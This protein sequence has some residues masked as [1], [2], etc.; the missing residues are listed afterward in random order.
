[1]DGSL[2]EVCICP[3]GFTGITCSEPTDA[4]DSCHQHEDTHICRHGGL[5]REVVIGANEIEWKCDCEIADEVNSFAGAMCRRPAT[6]YC[7]VHGTSFCTNGG[8]CVNNLVHAK[9]EATG[10]CICPPEFT[11]PHCE[12]LKVL[13]DNQ[14]VTH[15][16]SE[17][18]QILSKGIDTK[19]TE[20]NQER[21]PTPL[22]LS[23]VGIAA[24]LSIV[25]WKRRQ[26]A[27]SRRES[28]ESYSYEQSIFPLSPTGYHG[29]DGDNSFNEEE[30]VLQDVTLT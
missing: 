30:Y 29:N 19:G 9:F 22:T 2:R 20:N 8:T 16:V 28:S 1:V 11:G 13:V 21:S 12:F 24:I 27:I 15:T 26:A 7:N 3:L 6:E 14:D 25:W 18:D 10:D 4:L 5:C 17:D 23:L